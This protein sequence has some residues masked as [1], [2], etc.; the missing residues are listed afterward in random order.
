MPIFEWFRMFYGIVIIAVGFYMVG[1][2]IVLAAY[3]AH[4]YGW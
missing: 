4:L 1:F 3:L 2:A